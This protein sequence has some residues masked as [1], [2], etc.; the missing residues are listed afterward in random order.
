MATRNGGQCLVCAWHCIGSCGRWCTAQWRP[1]CRGAASLQKSSWQR[2]SWI[3]AASTTASTCSRSPCIALAA[4]WMPGASWMS[5]S[6][7]AGRGKLKC[8]KTA[9]SVLA[10]ADYPEPALSCQSGFAC[11]LLPVVG[12]RGGAGAV[13]GSPLSVCSTARNIF[14][15]AYRFLLLTYH[16]RQIISCS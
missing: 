13:A 2:R 9:F 4:C 7:C 3:S 12:V 8:F 1:T 11:Y 15:M 5:C 10:S 6:R 16:C 14:P